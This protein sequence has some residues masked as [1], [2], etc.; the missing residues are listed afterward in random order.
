VLRFEQKQRLKCSKQFKAV[1]AT[2]Q[3]I[4]NQNLNI[5]YNKNNNLHARLGV[6]V[7]KKWVPLAVNRNRIKRVIR[8]SFRL[9]QLPM[10]YD[11]VVVVYTKNGNLENSQCRSA[12]EKLWKKLTDIYEKSA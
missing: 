5:F 7:S 4:S 11:I 3:K 2:R 9:A 6:S 1:F 12:C 8:E 10:D